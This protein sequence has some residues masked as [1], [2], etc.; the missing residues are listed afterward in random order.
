MV[1]RHLHVAACGLQRASEDF[2]NATNAIVKEMYDSSPSSPVEGKDE[3]SRLAMKRALLVL[4]RHRIADSI[5]LPLHQLSA[6]EVS[7]TPQKW[8]MLVSHPV[9]DGPLRRLFCCAEAWHEK[10]DSRWV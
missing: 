10:E 1:H 9:T 6:P 3:Q 5:D 7:F 2:A 8:D 4:G